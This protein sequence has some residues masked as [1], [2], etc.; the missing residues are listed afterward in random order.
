VLQYGHI[1]SGDIISWWKTKFVHLLTLTLRINSMTVLKWPA[2][3]NPR[4]PT[5][6]YHSIP[7][8]SCS[9]SP[10]VQCLQPRCEQTT[11]MQWPLIF[12]KHFAGPKAQ[13]KQASRIIMQLACRFS[14]SPLESSLM[15]VP[16]QPYWHR[17]SC[18]MWLHYSTSINLSAINPL[19]IWHPHN[20]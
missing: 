5:V 3:S 16:L 7:V 4:G 11:H 9:G 2:S 19:L 18:R 17:P 13:Y 1:V 15:H 12:R 6:M 14:Q 20:N 10:C 8:L